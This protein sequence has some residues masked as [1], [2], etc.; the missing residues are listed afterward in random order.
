M[1]SDSLGEFHDRLSQLKLKLRNNNIYQR[2]LALDELA[3]IPSESALPIL[4]E[5]AASQ[6]FALRRIAVMGMGNHLTEKSFEL[7][8]QVLATEKDANVLAETANSL[9][10]FGARAIAPLEQLF[11]NS[12]NWLVHQTVISILVDGQNPDVLLRV[13]KLAIAD[14]DQ[15]TKETGILAL[16]RLLNTPLKQQA[17]NIFT[18]LAEAEYWRTRWRTAIAL[19]ASQDP[20]ARELLSQLQKDEHYRVVAAALE[21]PR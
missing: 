18:T 20:Q 11:S 3:T 21:V 5:L 10:E 16:S 19:T 13:A 2:K 17:L 14:D 6:D 15:T 7:L 12:D 4:I 1:D 9:F 8:M